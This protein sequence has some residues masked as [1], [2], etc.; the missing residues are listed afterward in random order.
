MLRLALKVLLEASASVNARTDTEETAVH[1]AVQAGSSNAVSAL[2][3]AS[4]RVQMIGQPPAFNN[5]H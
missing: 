3:E 1:R 2:L 4:G 5:K